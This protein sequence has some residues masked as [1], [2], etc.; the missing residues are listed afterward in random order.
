MET[1]VVQVLGQHGGGVGVVGDVQ[2]HGGLARQDLEPARQRG[3]QQPLAHRLLRHR[4]AVA[5]RFQRGQRGRRVQQLVGATQRRIGQRAAALF[6]PAIGPLLA[7]ARIVV[8][9]AEQPKVGADLL[10]MVQ[11]R[12]R[13]HRVGAHG[14]PAGTVDMGL[15]EADLLA[16]VAEIVDVVQVDAGDDGTVGVDDIDRVQA[17][18]QADFQHHG[19]QPR[20]REQAQ[21]RQRGEFE[22]RQRSVAAG[23]LDR[24][25]LF[26]QGLVR[27]DLAVDTGAF[28]EIDEVRRGVQADLVAR[29]QQDG[30]EHGAGR[31]LAVGAADHELHAGQFQVHARRHFPHAL[32]AHVDRDGVDGFQ[33]LE[34]IGQG[35]ACGRLEGRRHDGIAKMDS[36]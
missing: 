26:D 21:D 1:H 3:L 24:G 27:G 11:Q 28:V 5:H 34:P 7:I 2:D 25:E 6:A 9:A 16:R 14:G 23:G 18:A 10:D 13:R 33:V 15:L 12:L 36:P 8:V 31:A 32:Q 19:V 20:L 22:V 35:G 4:Q 29:G 30:L 17:A